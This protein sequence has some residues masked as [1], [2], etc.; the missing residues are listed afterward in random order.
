MFKEIRYTTKTRGHKL[1]VERISLM[2]TMLFP[3]RDV[4]FPAVWPAC[5]STTFPVLGVLMS[6]AECCTNIRAFKLRSHGIAFRQCNTLHKMQLFFNRTKLPTGSREDLLCPWNISGYA[7][8]NSLPKRFRFAGGL[9]E[10]NG[11]RQVFNPKYLQP[12]IRVVSHPLPPADVD[13]PQ[14]AHSP[15]CG[16]K[17]R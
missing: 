14:K 12:V 2:T 13:F 16:R 11:F 15:E 4:S 1:H 9:C 7:G 3:A 5:T 17:S 10:P 6:S 8:E